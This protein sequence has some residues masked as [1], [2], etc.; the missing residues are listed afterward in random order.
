MRLPHYVRRAPSGVFHFR[1][2]IPGGEIRRTLRT[3]DPMTAQLR[4][5]QLAGLYHSGM[6][7]PIDPKDRLS[8]ISTF[9]LAFDPAGSKLT[10]AWSNGSPEDNAALLKALELVRQPSLVAPPPMPVNTQP[11]LEPMTA[12]Q[13]ARAYLATIKAST[14]PKTLT[15]KA[16]AI[17]GFVR[18]FGQDRQINEA[19][20]YDLGTFLDALKISDRTKDNK[21][22]YL[23]G[24]WNWMNSRQMVHFAQGN[25]P[26]QGLVVLSRHQK[27]GWRAA[28]FQPFTPGQ[29]AALYSMSALQPLNIDQRWGALI[30]LYSG[31]R[32]SEVGQLA[33]EDFLE[34]DGVPC[35]Q[36]TDAGAGQSL[37]TDA[38]RRA[39]PLHPDLLAFGIIERVATLRTAGEKRF[40]PR[41][42]VDGVN[43]A[44]NWLSKAFSRHIARCGIPS[45][46]KGKLGFHSLRSTIVQRLQDAKVTDEVRAAI[47]GHVLDDEHHAVY[48][49]EPTKGE[50]LAAIRQV[51]FGLAL[52]AIRPLLTA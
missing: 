34:I 35:I 16:A 43:G 4:A 10:R 33:L 25:N 32:V 23:R 27:R 2:R 52:D 30:G 9:G 13:A 17:N 5:L 12:A 26:A 44:G 36:I 31:A 11:S 6:T 22:V 40:F 7:P 8:G 1:K 38:S 19:T 3:R 41:V 49:R 51:S 15:Q 46:G 20:G 45:P 50:M 29:V 39:V 21:Q 28:G 18:H 42:K 48:S 24:W 37:K 14:K 47:V